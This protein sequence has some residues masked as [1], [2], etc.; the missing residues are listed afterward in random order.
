MTSEALISST[1]IRQ[2]FLASGP[3]PGH[4]NDSQVSFAET[5]SHP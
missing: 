5:V 3:A 1:P 4:R 2:C